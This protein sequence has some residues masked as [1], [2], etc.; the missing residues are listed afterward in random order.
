MLSEELVQLIQS[1]RQQKAESRTIEVKAAH[2]GCP[3]KLYG[4]L[5]SFSNQDTQT[6][7]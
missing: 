2:D 5:S 1:L 6:C 4:T 7:R 3:Q